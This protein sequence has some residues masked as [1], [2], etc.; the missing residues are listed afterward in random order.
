MPD[1]IQ[2]LIQVRGLRKQLDG[3]FALKGIDLTIQS[4]ELIT[5]IGHS[6]CGKS[7]FLRCLNCLEIFDEG[8]VS[9]GDITLQRRNSKTPINKKFREKIYALRGHVGMVFQSFNLF[10]HLTILENIIRAPMIVQKKSRPEAE[11]IAFKLLEKVE[12]SNLIDRYPSQISGGQ[13]QRAAIARALAMSP[14]VMLYDEPTSALD[15][16]LV[17]EVLQVMKNLHNEGM[18]QVIVTH[19]IRFAREVS[20]FVIYMD[21]GQIVES[22]PPE[23]MFSSPNDERVRHYLKKFLDPSEL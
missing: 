6:G 13:Q 20:D 4:G 5:I 17:D 18:T 21:E 16:E 12:L 19:E 3:G 2:P 1:P 8:T 15:P 22:A 9:I 11:S 7:T 10:P 23:K 14:Q